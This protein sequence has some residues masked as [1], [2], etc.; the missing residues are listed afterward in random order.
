MGYARCAFEIAAQEKQLGSRFDYIFVACGSG[1]TVG[2]LI[3]GFKMLERMESSSSSPHPPQGAKRNKPPRKIIGIINSP[4]KPQTWHE[5][6]VLRFAHQ[7]GSLI[8]LEDASRVIT[9][10]EDVHLDGRFAGAAYGVLDEDTKA[11]VEVAARK[12]ALILDPVYTAKVLR[13]VMGWVEGGDVV[14]EW[15]GRGD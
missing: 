15:E 13:G 1:S 7:A 11:A 8:G 10:E 6:R 14:G 2:G 5:E 4:T 9:L 12:E 3:A